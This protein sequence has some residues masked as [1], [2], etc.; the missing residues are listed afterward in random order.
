MRES[1]LPFKKQAL[2]GFK[3]LIEM[4]SADAQ[5]LIWYGAS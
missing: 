2:H 5:E 4:I 3:I 1:A